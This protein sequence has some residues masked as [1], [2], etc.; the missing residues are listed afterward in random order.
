MKKF[1]SEFKAF[2]SRGN[3]VDMAVGI[4]FDPL[5][6]LCRDSLRKT[7]CDGVC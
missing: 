2:I 7:E 6:T 5:N 1:F 3:I 4:L